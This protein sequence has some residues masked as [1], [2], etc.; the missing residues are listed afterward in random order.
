MS[1]RY[2][3]ISAIVV[4]ALT[5]MISVVRQIKTSKEFFVIMVSVACGLV[6]LMGILV[7]LSQIMVWLGI[8]KSG[9]IF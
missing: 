7:G 4:F 3:W 2:Y 5:V 6:L 8:A 1:P 9:F